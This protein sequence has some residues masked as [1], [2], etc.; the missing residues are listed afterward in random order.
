MPAGDTMSRVPSSVMP[1]N[2]TLMFPNFLIAYGGE[3][4]APVVASN[5]VRGEELEVGAAEMA[6]VALACAGGVGRVAAAV[7]HAQQLGPPS[8][9]S[10][11]PTAL[12]SR[13]ILFIASMVGSSWKAAESSG[14]APMRSPAETTSEFG[15]VARISR[16]WLAR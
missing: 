2:P 5:D 4:R 16:M 11:L 6:A 10:W 1:M 13:P 8:S 12:R 15:L 3:Q 14:L 9:N 7:L